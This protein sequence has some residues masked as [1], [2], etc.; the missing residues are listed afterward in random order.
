MESL[1]ES[2]KNIFEASA[3][4]GGPYNYITSLETDFKSTSDSSLDIYRDPRR[5]RGEYVKLV[6]SMI[7][8]EPSDQKDE[9]GIISK[10]KKLWGASERGRTDAD[11]RR[12]YRTFVEFVEGAW[13]VWISEWGGQKDKIPFRFNGS[14]RVKLARIYSDYRISMGWP[15]SQKVKR[16]GYVTVEVGNGL[17][18]GQGGMRFENDVFNGLCQYLAAGCDNTRLRLAKAVEST[19]ALIHNS[20][21][22]DDLEAAS[23]EYCQIIGS[24][25]D[26]QET[27]EKIKAIIEKTGT[28]NVRRHI[29]NVLGTDT[30]EIDQKAAYEGRKAALGESGNKISDITIHVPAHDNVPSHDLYLSVKDQAAQ[31][32]GVVISPSKNGVNWMD[33]VLDMSPEDEDVSTP[34]TQEFNR[35]WSTMGIDPMEVRRGFRILAKNGAFKNESGLPAGQWVDTATELPSGE[36]ALPVQNKN[37]EKIGEVLQ[38]LIGGGYWY[39]SPKKLMYI[40]DDPRPWKFEAEKATITKTGRCVNIVGRVGSERVVLVIR[41]SD[42]NRKYPNRM[43]P[44]VNV[45]KLLALKGEEVSQ[46]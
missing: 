42:S 12:T 32:S 29:S 22:R 18:M 24:T 44:K 40:P 3:G 14:K 41:T 17:G 5:G 31:L 1:Y 9:K 15:M 33:E 23:K 2:I 7:G 46:A 13:Q 10:I 43:F 28:S 37:P 16:I 27:A 6:L 25:K 36:V 39:V 11:I 45:E 34:G 8:I 20:P 19:I 38:W 4:G 35:F 30:R 21:M 26:E